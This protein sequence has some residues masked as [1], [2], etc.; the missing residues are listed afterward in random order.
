MGSRNFGIA[1]SRGSLSVTLRAD[2]ERDLERLD[3]MIRE[4]AQKLALEYGL[5][6]LFHEQDFFPETVNDEEA[7][8]RVR[9]AAAALGLPVTELPA[10]SVVL[11]ISVI[12]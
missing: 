4:Q 11:R 2:Y 5:S 10:A 1:A 8:G 3:E 9:K 6:V 12:I 7:A